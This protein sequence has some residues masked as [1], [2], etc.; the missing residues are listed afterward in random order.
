MIEKLQ[1]NVVLFNSEEHKEM[2]AIIGVATDQGALCI[3][4]AS[5][6][7][8]TEWC[9]DR[10]SRAACMF[11]PPE[12]VRAL[13]RYFHVEDAMQALRMLAVEYAQCDGLQQIKALLQLLDAAFEEAEYLGGLAALHASVMNICTEIM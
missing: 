1:R 5:A 4:Q 7:E 2:L 6:G 8:F 3:W 10:S 11:I 12:S 9:F 13:E